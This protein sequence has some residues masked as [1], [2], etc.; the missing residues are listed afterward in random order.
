MGRQSAPTWSFDP[1]PCEGATWVASVI[2]GERD[3]SIRAPVRGRPVDSMRLLG[4]KAVSIR[5]PVR[6]RRWPQAIS[7]GDVE[8]RS[9][10]L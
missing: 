5:A 9:A 10:P 4:G 7:P 2:A 1:R 6:G 3:V 8:F